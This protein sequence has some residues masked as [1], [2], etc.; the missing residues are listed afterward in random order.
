MIRVGQGYDVHQLVPKRKLILGGVL[1]DFHLGL[2]GH[3][4]ADV[5]LHALIDSILGAA[6]LGD[7]GQ[8]FPDSDEDFKNIKSRDLLKE[9]MKLIELKKYKIGN[10]DATIICQTPKLSEYIPDMIENISEDC[11]CEK[12]QINI[13]ATTTEMMGYIGRSEGIAA[14]CACLIESIEGL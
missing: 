6:G 9:V 13:K 2:K 4:D 8:H 7:I 11:K 3:S 5:L 12:S 10:I 1:I 14:Q